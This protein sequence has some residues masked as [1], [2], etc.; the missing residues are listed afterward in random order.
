MREKF[1]TSPAAVKNELLRNGHIELDYT[2]RSGDNNKLDYYFRL[3][4]KKLT[5]EEVQIEQE[6]P[7]IFW[8]DGTPKS[9]GNAFDWQNVNSK[10]FTKREIVQA[11]QKYHNNHPITVYSRA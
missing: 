9:K 5:G 1:A 4:G 3:T 6:S 11:Q 10:L 2:K 7:E 8:A